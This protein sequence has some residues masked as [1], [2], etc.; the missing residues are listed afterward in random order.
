MKQHTIPTQPRKETETVKSITFDVKKP[1]EEW[2]VDD[3]HIWFDSHKVPDTL[4]KLF[5]FQS[6]AEM[7][8]YASKLRTD[9][10]TEFLKYGQRYAKLH[11]GEELE[12]YIFD[13]FKDA[14][15]SLPNNQTERVKNSM[16][17][18]QASIHKSSACT[19][20]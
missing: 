5:D 15:L 18:G 17:S 6:T 12:E 10:K 14:L 2:T 4:V 7:H 1:P 9:S 11:A 13:R 8:R 20:L 16:H 19:T 3:I